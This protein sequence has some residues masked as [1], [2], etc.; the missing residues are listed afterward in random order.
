MIKVEGGYFFKSKF[1]DLTD[2]FNIENLTDVTFVEKAG[3]DLPVIEISFSSNGEGLR[4]L[5]ENVKLSITIGVDET[6]QNDVL[7]SEFILQRPVIKYTGEGV[8]S[9]VAKGID[10]NLVNWSKSNVGISKKQS[11]VER[12]LDVVNQFRVQSNVSKSNDSQHWI[13]YGQPNK[14]HVEDVWMHVDL[15]NSFLMLAA[16][17][18]EFRVYDMLTLIDGEPSWYFVELNPR[19]SNHIVIDSDY[20]IENQSGFLNAVGARGQNQPQYNLDEGVSDLLSNAPESLL[21]ITDKLN[22]N[23]QFSKVHNE[24]KVLSRNVHTNYWRSF[25][26]NYTQMVLYSNVRITVSWSG[27]YYPVKPLDL[28]MFKETSKDDNIVQ[29]TDLYSGLYI[30]SKVSRRLNKNVFSTT[31]QMVR[32]NSARQVNAV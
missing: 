15:P 13:Q 18:D 7:D 24:R 3:T 4:R 29:S 23:E 1:G 11:G 5:N 26:H 12:I 17:L 2:F 20:T 14:L 25:I 6:P 10:S 16:C 22:I 32:E 8:W 21:A 31:V 19:A 28:V 9:V 27:A 30:V